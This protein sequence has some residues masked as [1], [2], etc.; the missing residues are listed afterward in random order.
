MNSTAIEWGAAPGIIACSCDV[1]NPK[2][3]HLE[4]FR[5]RVR[6]DSHAWDHL[7]TPKSRAP[8]LGAPLFIQRLNVTLELRLGTHRTKPRLLVELFDE[9]GQRM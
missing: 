8:P 6:I 9:D 5:T 1:W 2:G 3:G 7:L 4:A